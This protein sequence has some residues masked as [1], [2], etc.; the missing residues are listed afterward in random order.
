VK[1][2]T[3]KKE[4]LK[5]I[6][7][8][9]SKGQVLIFPTDTVYGLLCDA[10]NEKAVGRIFKIKKRKISKPLTVFVKD[11]AAAKRLAYINKDQEKFLK[12]N[13]P[14]AITVILKT[15]KPYKLSPLVYKDDTIGLRVPDYKLL[16]LILEKFNKPIAQTSANISGRSAVTKM[17]DVLEQFGNNDIQ[18]D[19]IINAGDLPKNKPSKVIDFTKNKM[20]ILRR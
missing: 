12:K 7:T 9:F 15:K 19:L 11:I 20:K 6:I 17:K 16:N 18:S 1:I 14:G 5:K 2:I 13:W 4:N 10:Y 8:A 3:A